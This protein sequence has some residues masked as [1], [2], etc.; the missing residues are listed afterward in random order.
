MTVL[1][2]VV[3][4]RVVNGGDSDRGKASV[5]SYGYLEGVSEFQLCAMNIE[6]HDRE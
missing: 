6:H 5:A 4:L 3:V 1:A 2:V